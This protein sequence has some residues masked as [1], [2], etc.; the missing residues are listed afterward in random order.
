METVVAHWQ[1]D[2]FDTVELRDHVSTA[3]NFPYIELDDYLRA[4]FESLKLEQARLL[5][6]MHHR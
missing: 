1:E 4:S 5:A 6:L 2:G 3:G